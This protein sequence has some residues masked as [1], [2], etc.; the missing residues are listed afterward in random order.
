MV[1][2]RR[3]SVVGTSGSGK[4]SLAR[5]IARRLGIPHVE[6]DAIHHQAGWTA[7]GEA[8]FRAAV[9]ERIAGDAWV[10]DGNYHGKLGDLV[11]RRADAVIWLDLPR[12]LVM[13][14]IVT[15]TV[16]RWVFR[17]ELWNGNRERLR[18]MFSLD[19]EQS[20][21][22]WAWTTHARNRERYLRAQRDPTYGHIEF[23]RVRSRRE[24]AA[25]L[26]GLGPCPDAARIDERG[27][28]GEGGVGGGADG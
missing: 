15:R 25:V 27:S 17:R 12:S 11:W 13:W 10:V 26:A 18:D 5:G 23:I 2:V 3:I 22:L 21:I 4:S 14:Q 20:V 8:E 16:G 6:L 24:G 1:A 19:P 7:M 28:A 9:G